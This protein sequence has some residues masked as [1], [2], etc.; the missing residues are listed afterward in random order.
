MKRYFNN[1]LNPIWRRLLPGGILPSGTTMDDM[2]LRLRKAVF[3]HEQSKNK[4][5]KEVYDEVQHL[6]WNFPLFA[7]YVKNGPPAFHDCVA[8]FNLNASQ[9]PQTDNGVLSSDTILKNNLKQN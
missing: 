2:L 9:G 4:T 8:A 6:T 1:E 5:K 3:E 7:A